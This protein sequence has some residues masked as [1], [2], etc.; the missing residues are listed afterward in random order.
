MSSQRLNRLTFLFNIKGQN[1][2]IVLSYTMFC[3]IHFYKFKKFFMVKLFLILY[4]FFSFC[5][6]LGLH[7]GPMEVPRLGVE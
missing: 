5:V 2:Q 4:F 7:Q 3:G 1:Q 6:F